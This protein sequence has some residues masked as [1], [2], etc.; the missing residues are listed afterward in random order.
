MDNAKVAEILRELWRYKDTDKYTEEEIR[1]ALEKAASAFSGGE[2]IKKEDALYAVEAQ[3][4][5]LL[6]NKGF[7]AKHGERDFIPLIHEIKAIPTR[8]IPKTA[9]S[10]EYIKKADMERILYSTNNAVRIGELFTELPTYS[11]PDSADI[12]KI[13]SEIAE[14]PNKYPMTADYE[15]GIREALSIID[16]H[17]GG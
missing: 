2:Y 11:I 8:S 12:E 17:I 15:N 5:H 16:K 4:K 3:L 7:V 14:I 13:R 9:T 10:G 6:H 1:E